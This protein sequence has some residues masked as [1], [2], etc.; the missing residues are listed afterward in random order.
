MAWA[1]W[2]L[3]PIGMSLVLPIKL[4]RSILRGAKPLAATMASLA[5][6]EELAHEFVHQQ[7]SK[8]LILSEDKARSLAA[9][10]CQHLRSLLQGVYHHLFAIHHVEVNVVMVEP[11]SRNLTVLAEIPS[12]RFAPRASRSL[13]LGRR[14]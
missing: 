5:I 14:H 8:S 7:S 13:H 6:L 12:T 1:W 9:V 4:S 3:S 11:I 2:Q 10:K